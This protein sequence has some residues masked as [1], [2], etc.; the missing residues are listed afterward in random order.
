MMPIFIGLIIAYILNPAV[1][2]FEKKW[3]I[4]I[5]KK[6]KKHREK[7]DLKVARALS[8]FITY[9]IG[10]IFGALFIK[11]VIPSLL[12]SLEVMLLNVPT[13][14]NNIYDYF[15]ENLIK[16]PELRSTLSWPM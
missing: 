3:T 13:Y 2:F 9:F 16:S 10:A 6:I 14:L 1:K 15:N 4:K 8:I 5:V 7:T 11:F 12:D